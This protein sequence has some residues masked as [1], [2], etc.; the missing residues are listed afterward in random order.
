MLCGQFLQTKK[1][2]NS[3]WTTFTTIKTSGYEQY[4]GDGGYCQ[5][6][7]VVWDSVGDLS[8][9]L[10]RQLDSLQQGDA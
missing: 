10:Q 9:S 6:P 3:E 4:I 7:S 1:G 8:P 2:D 5:R